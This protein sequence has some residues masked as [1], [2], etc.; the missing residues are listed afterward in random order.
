MKDGAAGESRGLNYARSWDK[1][2][3]RCFWSFDDYGHRTHN[4]IH[5]VSYRI[6]GKSSRDDEKMVL[7][8]LVPILACLNSSGAGLSAL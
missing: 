8:E 1:A 7:K 2:Q 4:S 6:I 3:S 5:K